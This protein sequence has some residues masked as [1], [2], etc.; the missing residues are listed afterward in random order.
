MLRDTYAIRFVQAGGGLAALRE[1]L[2][3]AELASVKRYQHFCEQLK[4]LSTVLKKLR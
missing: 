4:E 3:V 1:Q 2:G